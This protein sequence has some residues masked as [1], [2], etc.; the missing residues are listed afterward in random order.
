MM[1]KEVI[2]LQLHQEKNLDRILEK[3]AEK[4]T[5]ESGGVTLVFKVT[6]HECLSLKRLRTHYA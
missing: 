2:K 6:F 5:Q 4:K 1:E 3:T